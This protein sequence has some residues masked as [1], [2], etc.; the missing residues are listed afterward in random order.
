MFQQ[1][2]GIVLFSPLLQKTIGKNQ[3]LN[4]WFFAIISLI[5][6]FFFKASSCGSDLLLT[7]VPFSSHVV[8]L[9]Q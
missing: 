2:Q 5:T 1:V 8:C 3:F 4:Y 7:S 6:G 9:S